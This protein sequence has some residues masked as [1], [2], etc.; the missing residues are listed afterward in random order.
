MNRMNPI[1]ALGVADLAFTPML[2]SA[3]KGSKQVQ[4]SGTAQ[5][6]EG[7]SQHKR[8]PRASPYPIWQVYEG[9]RACAA[10]K[11]PRSP[12][13]ASMPARFSPYGIAYP[14]VAF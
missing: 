11:F 7:F 4:I 2:A 13:C 14:W 3:A 10:V 1:L 12:S 6:D 9:P 8:H 5:S